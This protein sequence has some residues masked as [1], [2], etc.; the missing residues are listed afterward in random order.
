MSTI[1]TLRTRGRSTA[2][3]QT[4]RKTIGQDWNESEDA[5]AADELLAEDPRREGCAP[6]IDDPELRVAGAS[7]A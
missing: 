4:S 3:I 7:P 1:R 6:R 5:V 2:W